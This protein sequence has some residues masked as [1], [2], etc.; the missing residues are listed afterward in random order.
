MGV[1]GYKGKLGEGVQKFLGGAKKAVTEET[2]TKTEEKAKKTFKELY[3]NAIKE[4][5]AT[6]EDTVRNRIHN[7]IHKFAHLSNIFKC[8]K[9]SFANFNELWW[10][11]LDRF[12]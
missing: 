1:L 11:L 8:I 3:E 7:F 10:I 12:I 5:K 9:F 6:L 4:K 2:G